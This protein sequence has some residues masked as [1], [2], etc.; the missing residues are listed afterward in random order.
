MSIAIPILQREHANMVK[1]LAVLDAEIKVYHELGELDL[2]LLYSIVEYIES[3]PAAVHHPKEEK[4]IFETLAERDS[5]ALP[6]I[7]EL[8]AQHE[9]E[10]GMIAEL[11]AGVEALS[12]DAPMD[13]SAFV[14]LVLQY[15]TFIYDHMLMEELEL[16]PMAR[17]SLLAADWEEID[18]AIAENRDPA[19]DSHG[20]TRYHELLRQIIYL[21]QPAPR[22]LQARLSPAFP[23]HIRKLVMG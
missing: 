7:A 16:F 12:I 8:R 3:F 6:L 22:D 13:K 19:F 2:D 17:E 1:V 9:A 10:K 4:F 18:K 11:R 21:S 5:E 20:G 23:S 14:D 15:T